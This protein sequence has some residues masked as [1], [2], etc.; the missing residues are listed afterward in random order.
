MPALKTGVS[1]YGCRIPWRV[2]EDLEEIRRNHCNFVVHTFS[3][4]D[5]E[6][7]AQAMARIVKDTRDLGLETWLDPWAV[8]QAFGGE[9]YSGLVMKRRDL[10]QIS[11]TGEQL[12]I[13]CPNH[14]EFRAYL[15]QWTK[16]SVEIGAQVLFWDE[17]HFHIYPEDG[18]GPG[19]NAWACR[20]S[21]CLE[22]YK[23]RYH[24]AMP[25]A[26]TAQVREFK[27]ESLIDFLAFL[28]REGRKHKVANAMCYLPFENSSTYSHW[29]KVAALPE[30]DVIGTDPY[31]RPHQKDVARHVGRSAARIA[32][33]AQQYKKEGQIWILNF[34]IK[35]GEEGRIPEAI[36][37]AYQAGIRNLA[38]W[39]YYGAGYI[40]L[41]SDDPKKVWETLG[42]SYAG[43][44]AKSRG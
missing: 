21:I 5:K 39:S 23:K 29:E 14:P 42:N 26:Q 17:P 13:C 43:L 28:C 6:F 1:Y 31:W 36:E 8:G 44:Q 2:R 27:E 32:K 3:E 37:A 15:A 20:C 41:A 25:A 16:V 9:T 7:Y 33:L 10:C 40:S 38:A 24:E 22:L 30:V 34:N 35:Q 18:T 12:P 11:A 4:E 19:G